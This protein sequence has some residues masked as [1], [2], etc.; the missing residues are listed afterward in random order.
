M[1]PIKYT[2]EVPLTERMKR[3]IDEVAARE[4]VVPEA[5]A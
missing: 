5:L 4:G 2:L 1:E 3:R